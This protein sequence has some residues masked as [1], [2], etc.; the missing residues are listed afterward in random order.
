[1]G[2]VG[3]G[4][5][6]IH[7]VLQV[8]PQELGDPGHL[9][10]IHIL[11]QRHERR[12]WGEILLLFEGLIGREQRHDAL[13]KLGGREPGEAAGIDGQVVSEGLERA[14][15]I[16]FDVVANKR[17]ELLLR[18]DVEPAFHDRRIITGAAGS[19]RL[20][21]INEPLIRH[22][23]VEHLG[24]HQ[25]HQRCRP[26]PFERVA[27]GDEQPDVGAGGMERA[28]RCRR[29]RGIGGGNLTGADRLT[30]SIDPRGGLEEREPLV[31]EPGISP[32]PEV[33][34]LPSGEGD[35]R[36]PG[37]LAEE[38]GRPPLLDSDSE[39]VDHRYQ[40]SGGTWGRGEHRADPGMCQL[41]KW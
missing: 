5:E 17:E 2:G 22:L 23:G 31:D 12:P 11:Q 24:T 38:P 15:R 32:V 21:V 37:E 20:E 35:L 6:S 28:D 14:D 1:M 9:G 7:P 8:A 13:G 26:S 16:G 18:K 33:D 25:R 39:E 10:S 30:G 40:A 41:V 36:M 29:D 19:G 27:K 3:G 4:A 34:L